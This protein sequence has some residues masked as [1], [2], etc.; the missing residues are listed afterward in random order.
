LRGL[1]PDFRFGD[2]IE[3]AFKFHRIA[4]PDGDQG[5]EQ[6]IGARAAPL[7]R[8]AD[9]LEL[10]ARPT[11]SAADFQPPLRQHVESGET[12]RELD[13]LMI[14]QNQRARPQSHVARV[15]S[16]ERQRLDRVEDVLET[17]GP[18]SVA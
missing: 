9:G 2:V 17:D 4:R 13:R 16:D 7:E 8:R 11:N 6:F 1:R 10:I 15:R 14:G 3:L 5:F 12:A 18:A